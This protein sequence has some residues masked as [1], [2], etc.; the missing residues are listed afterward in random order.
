M[1]S[2]V[3]VILALPFLLE[4]AILGC[5]LLALWRRTRTPFLVGAALVAFPAWLLAAANYGRPYARPADSATAEQFQ[6]WRAENAANRRIMS[7]W[8]MGAMLAGG[9]VA[10][11]QPKSASTP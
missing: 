6:Q 2:V 8:V 1:T 5:C 7:T 3:A 4:P 10:V 9:A 11:S